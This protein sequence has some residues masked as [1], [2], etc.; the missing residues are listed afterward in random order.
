MLNFLGGKHHSIW[1]SAG[2]LV[3]LLSVEIRSE[4]R[5][6][7]RRY[8]DLKHSG[9]KN[10]NAVA[11]KYTGLK[12]SGTKIHRIETQWHKNTQNWNIVAQKYT[13][14]KHSGTKIHRV[15]TQWHK[16]THN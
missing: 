11:Q 6:H 3:K 7:S 16:N 13:E 8:T 9:V 4:T 5:W 2:L 12:H 14:L 15:E 1:K 10:T